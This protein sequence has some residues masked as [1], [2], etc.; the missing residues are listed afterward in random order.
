M[1]GN[2]RVGA[3]VYV[4]VFPVAFAA[5]W[6][7]CRCARV[8]VGPRAFALLAALC[9]AG[10]GFLWALWVH[11]VPCLWL[12]CDLSEQDDGE[13]RGWLLF[14]P[15]PALTLLFLWAFCAH[16]SQFKKVDSTSAF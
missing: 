9:A 5:G 3:V 16:K 4:F 6:L 10:A 12:A 7:A 13:L 15:W 1:G 11:W 2:E 8:E 14:A